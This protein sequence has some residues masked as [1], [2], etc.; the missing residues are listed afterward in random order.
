MRIVYTVIGYQSRYLF[1]ES[2]VDQYRTR[3]I[4]KVAFWAWV[5][6]VRSGRCAVLDVLRSNLSSAS[7]LCITASLSHC[8]P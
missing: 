6:A 7:I 8:W 4:S 5:E 3:Q 2:L 1:I